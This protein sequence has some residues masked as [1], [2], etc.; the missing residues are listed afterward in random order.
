[1]AGVGIKYTKSRGKVY[2][3]HCGNKFET[4]Q[5][6]AEHWGVKLKEAE[7]AVYFGK[8]EYLTLGV[9]EFWVDD[10]FFESFKEMCYYLKIDLCQFELLRNAGVSV[11]ECIEVLEETPLKFL[12]TEFPCLEDA[13]TAL[14]FRAAGVSNFALESDL[15]IELILL[16]WNNRDKLKATKLDYVGINGKAY[17]ISNWF[18]GRMTMVEIINLLYPGDENWAKAYLRDHPNEEHCPYAYTDTLLE[19]YADIIP[20]VKTTSTTKKGKK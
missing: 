13:C 2:I 11:E 19:K 20:G 5:D 4:V 1:M 9:C 12:G 3:D 6:M 18:E 17:Y 7:D 16:L 15:D 10:R 8:P 14:K